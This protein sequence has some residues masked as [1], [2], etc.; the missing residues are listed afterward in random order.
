M[1]TSIDISASLVVTV[2]TL[3]QVTAFKVIEAREEVS[4]AIIT[5][6]MGMLSGAGDR[7]GDKGW[8]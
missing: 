8:C 6:S 7:I 3:S 4:A 2:R 5:S 1:S